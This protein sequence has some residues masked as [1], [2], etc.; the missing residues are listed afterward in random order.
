MKLTRSQFTLAGIF[1]AVALAQYGCAGNT[2][3]NTSNDDSRWTASR[4]S[5]TTPYNQFQAKLEMSSGA[6][7]LGFMKDE[8]KPALDKF[9]GDLD[10]EEKEFKNQFKKW[11]EDW[12]ADGV[13]A[14][15]RI[16]KKNYFFNVGYRTGADAQNDVKSGRS[17]GVGPTNRQSDPSDLA[18]LTELGDYLKKERKDSKDF[19]EAIMLALTNNDPSGWSN[20]SEDG[21]I[22]A[23][24][25]MAIYTAEEDRHLMVN[26]KSHPW[27]IDLAAATFASVYV[28]ETDKM[29]KGGKLTDGEIKNWWAKGS[30]GSGIGET[31]RDRQVLTKKITKSL[32]SNAAAKKATAAIE[33][34]VGDTSGDVIQSTFEFLGDCSGPK[35]L[36]SSQVKTLTQGFVDY[37][38]A[39]KANASDVE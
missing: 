38:E 1:A 33:S 13:G 39:V 10:K 8:V 21:Q 27:E 30:V 23:T 3:N 37:M 28:A 15:V 32:A 20:L 24:D 2:V 14:A 25:F 31:R 26:C 4:Q 7:Y 16:D 17:Y 29:V 6:T 19:V 12:I 22:V 5:Q 11:Q 36:T 9:E 34:V 18:Y 35:K